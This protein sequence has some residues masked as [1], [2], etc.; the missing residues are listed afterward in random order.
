MSE[1]EVTYKV[2]RDWLAGTTPTEQEWEAVI[3]ED[4]GHNYSSP[5]G[6]PINSGSTVPS[7]GTEV[8]VTDMRKL[9]L[10]KKVLKTHAHP[11]EHI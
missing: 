5:N 11:E 4:E 10:M 2:F 7:I 3:E 1:D 6:G 9:H 8:L